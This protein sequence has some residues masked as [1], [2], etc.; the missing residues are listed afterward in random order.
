M[1]SNKVMLVG[2]TGVGKTSLCHRFLYGKFP[3]YPGESITTSKTEKI[4]SRGDDSIPVMYQDTHGFEACGSHLPPSLCRGTDVILMVYALDDDDSIKTLYSIVEGIVKY[5]PFARKIMVGNKY[6]LIETNR[7]IESL[8]S[9]NRELTE[10]D[11]KIKVSALTGQGIQELEGMILQ[12]IHKPKSEYFF[13]NSIKMD[14]D[15]NNPLNNN[16]SCCKVI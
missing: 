9:G 7:K 3:N 8:I 1:A 10:V 11:N 4:Y 5:M 13:N 2:E 12:L 16:T 6:D 15:Y 14:G